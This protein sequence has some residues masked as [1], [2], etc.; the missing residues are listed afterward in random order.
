ML[1]Q[2]IIILINDT[3]IS[4]YMCGCVAF[5]LFTCAFLSTDV[6]QRQHQQHDQAAEAFAGVRFLHGGRSRR[7]DADNSAPQSPNRRLRG[8]PDRSRHRGLPG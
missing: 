1:F 8:I 7:A 2:C 3:P 5:C 6:F 4:L